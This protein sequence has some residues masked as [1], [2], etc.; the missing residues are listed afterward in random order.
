M[1]VFQSKL[2]HY[3][4]KVKLLLI[5]GFFF[6]KLTLLHYFNAFRVGLYL[7]YHSMTVIFWTARLPCDATQTFGKRETWGSCGGPL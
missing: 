2:Y 5:S 3:H 7:C 1:L 4:F 6:F